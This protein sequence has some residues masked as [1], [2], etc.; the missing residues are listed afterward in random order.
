M[1]TRKSYL[2]VL[3]TYNKTQYAV[4]YES[5]RSDTSPT[6]DAKVADSRII[7]ICV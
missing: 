2:N 1:E 7:G 6:C 4:Y 3:T 5:G